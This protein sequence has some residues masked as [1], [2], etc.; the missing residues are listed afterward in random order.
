MLASLLLLALAS[1]DPG[2]GYRE[3]TL[4]NGLRVVLVE[5][6]ANPMVASSVLVGAGVVYEPEGASGTSHLLEHLL[7]N[8]TTTR[9]QREIYDLADRYGAY[10]N[11]TTREDHTLFSLLIQKEFAEQG[12]DLQADMLFRS[13]IPPENFEKEKGIVLE[14][15]A[16]DASDPGYAAE[17]D[18]RAFA[19][20]GSPLARPVLGTAGS[21]RDVS[22]DTVVAYYRARYVPSNLLLVVM[23]DFDAGAMLETVK[24][25]FG[26]APRGDPAS[27]ATGAFRPAPEK[28][29][30]TAPLDAP[31]VYVHAAFPLGVDAHDP[32]VPAVELLLGAIG[33][34]DDAPLQRALTSGADAPALAVSLDLAKRAGAWSTVELSATLP[35][36]KP[37]APILDALAASIRDPEPAL[38][39]LDLVRTRARAAEI[40]GADQIHYYAMTHADALLTAPP[41]WLAQ[42][43]TRFD[44][45]DSSRLDAAAALL[46]RGLGDLRVGVEG[47]GIADGRS[48][49]KPPEA[50]PRKARDLADTTL[51]SGMRILARKSSD[52]QVFAAHLLLRP[53]SASEPE[54][55]EGIAS[56]LH[57]LMGRGMDAR[58]AR[59]G[60]SLKTDDDPRVPF[61]DYY[62]TPE[63][64]F[65]RL[66]VPSDGWREAISLLGEAVGA[67]P[68]D[69]ASVEAVRREMADVR[70]RRAK[71]SRSRAVDALEQKL[72]PGHPLSRAVLGTDAS[73]ASVTADDLRS[74]REAYVTGRRAIVTVVS[75]VDP[76]EVVAA[77]AAAFAAIGPEAEPPEVPPVPL[78]PAK[79]EEDVGNDLGDAVTIAMAYDF[80]APDADRPALA[81][82]GAMLSDAL[83]FDLR[84]TRG[85]AYSIGAS[86]APWGG[87]MRLLVTMST[88]KA[89]LD[90]ALS[91]L[92][93]GVAGFAPKDDDAVRRAAAALRGRMLMR[94]LTRIN[95]AYFAGLAA[96]AGEP[97]DADL[98][99]LEAL[100]TLDREKV[101]AA[102]KKYLDAAR[103][104]VVVR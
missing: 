91:G 55:K 99:R 11:A 7:F 76:D 103:L 34:G 54:G 5:H 87:R 12:L 14:E 98:A 67:P 16:R 83:A 70:A 94:R 90:E 37:W 71:S 65:V 52:S 2:A 60:A 74:F 41:G 27:P 56:F 24:R 77:V 4:D 45:I 95:L 78:S 64:S 102:S 48:A 51:A 29:V 1:P 85:L 10:N 80:D 46:R 32:V 22:R 73:V 61:D 47:P 30:R 58:L 66:E 8:G 81:V 23:G 79:G 38:S 18:F 44:G 6:H 101:A 3:A 17:Q 50:A 72:A 39:R 69:A 31:R 97:P 104:T 43:T 53:R 84:E 75:P 20:A 82:A 96:M 15:M 86:I 100:L 62:T 25:T 63:F 21:I 13:T 42:A 33:D 40:L 35:P 89:N 28:N 88:R 92:R 59:I 57:R 49:W 93:E 19:C 26:S 68:F 36:G 9:T